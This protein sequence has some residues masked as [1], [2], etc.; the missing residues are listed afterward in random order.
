[1]AE[2]SKTSTAWQTV[3]KRFKGTPEGACP[4]LAAERGN[5]LYS[6]AGAWNNE[7][8]NVY[9]RYVL[10]GDPNEYTVKVPKNA[11][12]GSYCDFLAYLSPTEEEPNGL[13]TGYVDHN[14]QWLVAVSI[15][16]FAL[17]LWLFNNSRSQAYSIPLWFYAG[18]LL[19]AIYTLLRALSPAAEGPSWNSLPRV[20]PV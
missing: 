9:I 8:S 10:A 12:I 15:V 14:E 17:L 7:Y 2:I 4:V 3:F 1:M 18:F 5:L 13:I 19:V 11:T 16:S 6:Y 20:I